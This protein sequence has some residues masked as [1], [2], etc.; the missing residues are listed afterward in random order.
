MH[1]SMSLNQFKNPSFLCVTSG[2]WVV[3][4]TFVCNI[5]RVHICVYIMEEPSNLDKVIL[6][7]IW[8]TV[9]LI[10]VK[11]WA[12]EDFLI[13]TYPTNIYVCLIL[14][15]WHLLTS[16][17]FNTKIDVW[18]LIP[19]IHLYIDLTLVLNHFWS[20]SCTDT[21]LFSQEVVELTFWKLR[22]F[23]FWGDCLLM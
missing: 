14:R 13:L 18:L 10:Q 5:I 9:A 20:L 21:R 16:K 1:A 2:V 7:S 3:H 11:Y 17:F 4:S 19:C 22:W 12:Y 6:V 8:F 23:M 15:S